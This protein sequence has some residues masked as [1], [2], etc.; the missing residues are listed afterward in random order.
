[1][2]LADDVNIDEYIMSKDDLSGADIKV[3]GKKS[4][5]VVVGGK[6]STQLS[7]S[8]QMFCHLLYSFNF[9]LAPYI[10]LTTPNYQ[11]C[12]ILR[13]AVNY[14]NFTKPLENM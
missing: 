5:L 11:V 12:R 14:F 2:T 13:I 6:C 4:T 1:M 10:F 9:F 7:L 8:Y 3:G